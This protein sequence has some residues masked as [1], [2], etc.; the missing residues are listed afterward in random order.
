MVHQIYLLFTDPWVRRHSHAA[1]DIFC[2]CV[3][4]Y[5]IRSIPRDLSTAVLSKLACDNLGAVDRE[6][7]AVVKLEHG[8][9]YDE[10]QHLVAQTVVMQ[11]SLA[12]D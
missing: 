9:F 6:H 10:C 4:I 12:S 8:V 2:F 11:M 5:T 1:L 3:R 7:L